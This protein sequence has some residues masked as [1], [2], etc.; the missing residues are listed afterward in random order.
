MSLQIPMDSNNVLHR[1][2]HQESYGWCC[3][4]LHVS[5]NETIGVSAGYIAL[6]KIWLMSYKEKLQQ[7]KT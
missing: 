4:A 6:S 5:N 7:R 1:R 2:I 3:A